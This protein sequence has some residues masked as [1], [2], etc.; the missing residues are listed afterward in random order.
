M[1]DKTTSQAQ[2]DANKR[3]REKNKEKVEAQRYRSMAR[4]FIRRFA[5]IEN[6][7]ELETLI[8]ERKRELM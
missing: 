1:A 6:L 2:L 4:S 3:W 8:E 7:E 5:T